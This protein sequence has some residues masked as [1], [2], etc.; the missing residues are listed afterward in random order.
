MSEA[1]VQHW[2]WSGSN[3]VCPPWIARMMLNP[4][5]RWVENPD[6]L[7]EGHVHSGD[8]AVDVGCAMGYYSLPLARRVGRE[9][10]VICVDLQPKMLEGLRKRA[11]S[12][13][14]VDRLDLRRCA[15]DSLPLDDVAGKV[16]VA[17]VMHVVHEAPDPSALFRQLAAAMQRGGRV[18]FSEPLGHVS[19]AAFDRSLGIAAQAGLEVKEPLRI[20]WGRGRILH[21]IAS[22]SIQ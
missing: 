14:L 15:P 3:H 18:L 1:K 9:G 4:L 10:R 19:R 13:G 6:V 5:R 22:Q 20:R 12:R 11:S 16:A 2:P 21:K 8:L 17:L 7:L